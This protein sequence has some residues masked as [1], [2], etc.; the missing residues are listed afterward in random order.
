MYVVLS[1]AGCAVQICGQ[2]RS[3]RRGKNEGGKGT[4]CVYI[5]GKSVI[6]SEN[7]KHHDMVVEMCLV[8]LKNSMEG[9]VAA[10]ERIKRSSRWGSQGSGHS[11][12]TVS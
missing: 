7:S 12:H 6:G 4:G 5:C 2:G 1:A 9:G 8:W 11:D 3:H 10:A